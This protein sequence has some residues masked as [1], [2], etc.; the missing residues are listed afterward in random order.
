MPRGPYVGCV[1]AGNRT[2][3][4]A[5]VASGDDL[6]G[7]KVTKANARLIAAAPDLLAAL[8]TVLLAHR[9]DGAM[10][11]GAA[12]LSPA[13]AGLVERAITKAKGE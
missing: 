12:A 3:A 13:I 1:T 2:V 11:L 8:E 5:S 9:Y 10:T 6:K 7:H 4:T